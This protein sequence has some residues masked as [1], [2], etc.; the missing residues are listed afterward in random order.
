MAGAPKHIL[1]VDDD[2]DVLETIVAAL[3]ERGYRVTA[4]SGGV[5]MRAAIINPDL[6]DA[7]VLD[8]SMP[9]E[10]TASLALHAKDRKLPV[11][12]ISGSPTLMKFALDNGLQLL[13]KP[14]K[15][16]ELYAAIDKALATAS[17][18]FPI[19]GIS[20]TCATSFYPD[21]ATP[22]SGRTYAVISLC[23]WY[24]KP[25][26]PHPTRQIS[27]LVRSIPSMAHVPLTNKRNGPHG[28]DTQRRRDR[29]QP[30]ERFDQSQGS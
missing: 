18:R 1:V 13:M 25:V 16:D 15:I 11:V 9:G 6:L 12:M 23:R 19:A 10:N 4:S 5:S 28:Q 8:A 26:R 21:P 27:S 17:G 2:G 24:K 29:R 3:Q 30:E 22:G 20:A 7:I 14:F